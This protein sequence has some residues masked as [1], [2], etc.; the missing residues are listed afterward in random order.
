MAKANCWC[1]SKAVIYQ[2]YAAR[3][4][5]V[6]CFLLLTE[7]RI[8]KN[9]L[10]NEMVQA[11]DRIAVAFS[12]GKD[13]TLALHYFNGF[14]KKIPLEVFA[15][16]IDEGIKGYRDRSLKYGKKICRS[17]GIEQHVYS[18]KKLFGTTLD[19][20]ARK[21]KEKAPCSYCGVLRRRAI[22]TAALELKA[23]KVA[24]GHNLDDEV[25]AIML[26]YL[27]GDSERLARLG[28]KNFPVF[29]GLV[30]RIKPLRTIPEKEC[31]LYCLLK[32][33]DVHTA[34]CPYARYAIRNDVR[35][36]VNSFE[37]KYPGT[38]FSILNGLDKMLPALKSGFGVQKLGSCTRCGEPASG[39][40]CKVCDFLGG[41]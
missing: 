2:P 37:L 17:F 22:N 31:M 41:L 8:K 39:K 40:L 14:R 27:R 5:C 32:G 29:D 30:P 3:H 19:Q 34:E 21:K 13:S 24:T 11:G 18:F 33:F 1:G 15:I 23:N 35:G 28:P 26:N 16:T 7:K 9:M 25:Q 10:A 12:G 36:L 6:K 38:K 4:Y 20:I